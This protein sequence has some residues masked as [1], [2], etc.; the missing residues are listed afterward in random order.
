MRVTIKHVA[1]AAHVSHTTVSRVFHQDPR[2][3]KATK[4]RVLEAAK[5]LN[6][7]PNIMA[8]G[9]VR[10]QTFLIGLVV[11]DIMSSFFPEIIGGIEEV[12]NQKNYSIILCTSED[13][14]SKEQNHVQSLLNKGVD[15]LIIS[16]V[17]GSDI[18]EMD[19][20][21]DQ[22]DKH[23]VYLARKIEKVKGYFVGVNDTQ[24]GFQATEHLIKLGHRRIAHLAGDSH[25]TQSQQRQQ[26]FLEAVRKHEININQTLIIPSGYTI[27]AGYKSARELLAGSFQPPALYAVSDVTAIGAIQAIRESGLKVPQ[28]IAV[29]GTDDLQIASLIEIPLTTVAQPKRQ[30]GITAAQIL[31]NSI[32]GIQTES[33]E[34]QTQLIIRESCGAKLQ[35][36][37][38]L[39]GLVSPTQ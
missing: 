36:T 17:Y 11:P 5:K 1:H 30:M 33:V 26:G 37:S 4:V 23:V 12:T 34:L 2:I 9:L 32:E 20:L 22:E 7:R 27:E 35:N 3:S 25:F 14:I 13:D 38:E 21:I 10:Q 15:G 16:P 8:R 39:A 24:I 19:Q 18:A 28:D 31:I 29:V 6:Y